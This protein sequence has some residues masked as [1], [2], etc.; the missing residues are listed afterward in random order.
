MPSDRPVHG[1]R[2]KRPLS[3]AKYA[4]RDMVKYH[5]NILLGVCKHRKQDKMTVPLHPT[6][7]LG[8]QVELKSMC[9]PGI[10]AS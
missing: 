10:M 7:W 1:E 4:L 3:R 2:R 5:S 6:S 8:S 9:G